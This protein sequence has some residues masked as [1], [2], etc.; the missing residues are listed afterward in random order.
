MIV[1]R[2]TRRSSGL[3]AAAALG[4]FPLSA[5]I[6]GNIDFPVRPGGAGLGAVVDVS[7]GLNLGSGESLYAGGRIIASLPRSAVWV[8]GG[9]AGMGS[10]EDNIATAGGGV[11]VALAQTGAATV[12][13]DVGAGVAK[14]GG[15]LLLG[16]T[17][18]PTLW[19]DLPGVPLTPFVHAHGL[20][21]RSDGLTDLGVSALGGA[22]LEF[23]ALPDVHVAMQWE[24]ADGVDAVV[25]G[26]GFSVP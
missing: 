3:V 11:A 12:S 20:L 2:C 10:G 8:G 9:Y 22:K 1:L 17:A 15:L 24:H 18:G 5:Q 21:V 14:P 16:V 4:V 6:P 13:I 19:L 23:P 7:Q 26:G 25:I